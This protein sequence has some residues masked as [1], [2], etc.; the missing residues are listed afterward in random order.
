MLLLDGGIVIEW[1]IGWVRLAH[2]M[3]VVQTSCL[4]LPFLTHIMIWQW[5]LPG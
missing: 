2:I 5:R 4:L 1:L 3:F